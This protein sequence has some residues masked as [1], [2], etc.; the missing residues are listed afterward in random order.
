MGA[1][2]QKD[3]QTGSR[4]S[5]RMTTMSLLLLLVRLLT[6]ALAGKYSIAGPD[7]TCPMRTECVKKLVDYTGTRM[8]YPNGGGSIA[9]RFGSKSAGSRVPYS[10]AACVVPC[11]PADLHPHA[12][13]HR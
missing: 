1:T 4:P 11:A 2:D 3:R 6:P 10:V 13:L 12:R 9:R 5:M 7:W 8:R